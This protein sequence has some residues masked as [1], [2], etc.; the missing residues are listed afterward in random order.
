MENRIS[1][2]IYDRKL[3]GVCGGVG[4]YFNIDPTWIRLGWIAAFF[5]FGFGFLAYILAWMIIPQERQYQ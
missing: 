1:R 3:G 2:S 5:L 4:R